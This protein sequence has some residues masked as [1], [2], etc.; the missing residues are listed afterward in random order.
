MAQADKERETNQEKGEAMKPRI[1]PQEAQVVLYLA[2]ALALIL[3]A[4]ALV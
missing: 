2:F 4:L 3:I 1:K